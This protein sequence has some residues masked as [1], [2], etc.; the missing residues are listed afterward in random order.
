MTRYTR[1][2][3]VDVG[4][5]ES[6]MKSQSEGA[7]LADGGLQTLFSI[8][9]CSLAARRHCSSNQASSHQAPRN[10]LFLWLTFLIFP[11]CCIRQRLFAESIQ[12]IIHIVCAP[13]PIGV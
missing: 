12:S 11:S 4:P 10:L 8:E 5:I 13:L 3:G 1:P 2:L 6:V 7:Q 9:I